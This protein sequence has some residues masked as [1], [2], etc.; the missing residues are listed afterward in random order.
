MV[1]IR[2]LKEAKADLKDIYDYI[3]SDSKRYGRLQVE[4]IKDRTQILKSHIEIGKVVEEVNDPAI[5]ELI[6]GNHR[7]I[8]RVVTMNRIDVLMVHHGARDLTRRIK[9]L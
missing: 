3:S 5:R 8:Y 6:E 2:W 7:I 1:Q 9:L 4:R